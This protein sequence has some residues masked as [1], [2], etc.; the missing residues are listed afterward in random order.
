MNY[1]LLV[2][3]QFAFYV[4]PIRGV[5]PKYIN[6][7]YIYIFGAMPNPYISPSVLSHIAAPP[8]FFSNPS[9]EL[10]TIQIAIVFFLNVA[11]T[12]MVTRV[13]VYIYICV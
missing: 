9:A 10:S 7:I 11:F 2:Q 6:N 5:K 3:L 13:C 4:C 1:V 12:I 8:A